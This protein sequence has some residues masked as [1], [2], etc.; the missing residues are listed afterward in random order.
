MDGLGARKYCL[1]IRETILYTLTHHAP[2]ALKSQNN[3][4]RR[5]GKGCHI[6][7]WKQSGTEVCSLINSGVLW[8]TKWTTERLLFT[9][10]I[11]EA[12]PTISYH[13]FI[14]ILIPTYWCNQIGIR[15]EGQMWLVISSRFY[16]E[17]P[18][19]HVFSTKDKSRLVAMTTSL[20]DRGVKH[21]KKK[22]RKIR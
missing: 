20:P 14:G 5:Y 22:I 13:Q 6:G 17:P 16:G 2:T 4:A 7:K 9:P 12:P 19:S 21:Q 18:L 10:H 3:L 8:G 1:S 15:T 11:V